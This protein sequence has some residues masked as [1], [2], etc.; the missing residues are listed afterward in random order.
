MGGKWQVCFQAAWFPWDLE[1]MNS[2][3]HHRS[4]C[5][6][7]VVTF[8]ALPGL[9]TKCTEF[10]CLNSPKLVLVQSGCSSWIN[11]H[12]KAMPACSA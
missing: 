11:F 5:G 2:H 7:A 6:L 12:V 4:W 9:A 1:S 8:M 10:C 3:H